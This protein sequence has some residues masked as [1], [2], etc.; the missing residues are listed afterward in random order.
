M[1]PINVDAGY[2]PAMQLEMNP[3]ITASLNGAG[4]MQL[5][6]EALSRVRM[7]SPQSAIRS[8][9]APRSA[10]RVAMEARQRAARE[11]RG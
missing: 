6:H 10:R 9:E 7:R 4:K 5:L 2:L 3:G 11:L 1:H 8:T